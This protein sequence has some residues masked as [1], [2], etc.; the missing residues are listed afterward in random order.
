M[1]PR[2]RVLWLDL[3]RE[4]LYARI[5]ARVRHM[6]SQGWLEEVRAL[7]ALSRPLSREASKALGYQE[8]FA[9]PR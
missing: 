9:F 3:P 7:R 8:M 6:F 1:D 5:N 2:N 4:E